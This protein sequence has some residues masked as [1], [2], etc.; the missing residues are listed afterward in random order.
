MPK[1]A[2]RWNPQTQSWEFGPPGPGGP[3]AGP[4]PDREPAS[5]GAPGEP[6]PAPAAAPGPASGATPPPGHVPAPPAGY[7]PSTAAGDAPT[8]ADGYAATPADGYAPAPADGY[9]PAEPPTGYAP[10]APAGYVPGQPGGFGPAPGATAGL[11][12]YPPG[13]PGYGPGPDGGTPPPPP[14]PARRGGWLT[15]LT[16]G[17]A[18]AALVAGAGVVWFVQRGDAP[19]PKATGSLSAPPASGPSADVSD[20]SDGEGSG[21]PSDSPSP[22]ASASASAPAGYTVV[23]DAAGFRIAVPEGWQREE[24][25]TGVFYRSADRASLVQVFR[26]DEPGMTARQAV[27]GASDGLSGNPGYRQIGITDIGSGSAELTYEYDSAETGSRRRGIERVLTA[28]DGRMY[29][30]LVAAPATDWPRQQEIQTAALEAFEPG[31]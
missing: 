15:P 29:A 22:S 31:A 12:A 13:P 11:P 9:A 5:E 26:V 19:A 16:A 17:V 7:A 28:P 18:V 3:G 24:Q 25:K 6:A 2:P 4:V 30:V 10:A 14:R 1:S 20:Q 21:S 23:D 8:P 27:Q